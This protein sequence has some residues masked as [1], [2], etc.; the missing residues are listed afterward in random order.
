MGF[1]E[2]IESNLE[3]AGTNTCSQ[4]TKSQKETLRKT[5]N[6]RS[7]STRLQQNRTS[8]NPDAESLHHAGISQIVNDVID[9]DKNMPNSNI[10]SKRTTRASRAARKTASK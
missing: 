10:G 1:S 3:K 2:L 4:S 8:T 6:K 5:N 9:E 7:N